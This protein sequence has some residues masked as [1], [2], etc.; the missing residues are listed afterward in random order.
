MDNTISLQTVVLLIFDQCK[1][2]D[3]ENVDVQRIIKLICS[4]VDIDSEE[5]CQLQ[6][7]ELFKLLQEEDSQNN[8]GLTKSQF[9]NV[10]KIWI[11]SQTNDTAFETDDSIFTKSK[12]YRLSRSLT[13]LKQQ[14]DNECNS[15]NADGWKSLCGLLVDNENICPIELDETRNL[16]R[17]SSSHD[18]PFRIPLNIVSSTPRK[19]KVRSKNH[20]FYRDHSNSTKRSSTDQSRLSDSE[21]LSKSEDSIIERHRSSILDDRDDNSLFNQSNSDEK[22]S[23]H[24][25]SEPTLTFN[26]I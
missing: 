22:D 14:F 15:K 2:S 23:A 20:H 6:F 26:E 4:N 25:L 11:Q 7:S 24:D 16:S 19:T 10:F 5:A 8:N 17:N 13:N 9:E 21:V 12:E 3:N 18:D 1:E